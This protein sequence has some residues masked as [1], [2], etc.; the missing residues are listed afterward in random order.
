MVNTLYF[1]SAPLG[2]HTHVFEVILPANSRAV[3][4]VPLLAAPVCLT[5]AINAHGPS[6]PH[7]QKKTVIEF[8]PYREEHGDR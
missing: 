8:N 7:T 1:C 4:A 5:R 6:S 2:A 3:H